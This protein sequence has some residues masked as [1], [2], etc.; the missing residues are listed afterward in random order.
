[1]ASWNLIL[2]PLSKTAMNAALAAA[3]PANATF[4]DVGYSPNPAEAE[5]VAHFTAAL[6]S[7]VLQV[8]ALASD[9]PHNVSASMSGH[10][11][12]NASGGVYQA[13]S[14]IAVSVLEYY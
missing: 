10:R 5:F 4:M 6:A 12:E 3:V 2:G 13:G 9:P 8:G 11:D 1:M 7:A 14:R